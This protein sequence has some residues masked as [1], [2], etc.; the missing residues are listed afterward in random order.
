MLGRRFCGGGVDELSQVSICGSSARFA[1]QYHT[2]R[3]NGGNPFLDIHGAACETWCAVAVAGSHCTQHVHETLEPSPR[4][5]ARRLCL[6]LVV[7]SGQNMA[8][9]TMHEH[10]S[11]R[12]DSEAMKA[13]KK[14][15][16][17][18]HRVE[19]ERSSSVAGD[20][21]EG[22]E[23]E[24]GTYGEC[25]AVGE[26]G[27]VSGGCSSEE[28]RT[29]PLQCSWAGCVVGDNAIRCCFQ[30]ID[31]QAPGEHVVASHMRCKSRTAELRRF[32]NQAARAQ[33][34]QELNHWL[35]T[36]FAHDPAIMFQQSVQCGATTFLQGHRRCV[37]SCTGTCTCLVGILGSVRFFVSHAPCL[38]RYQVQSLDS[39]S[40]DGRTC[41]TRHVRAD[42]EWPGQG[43]G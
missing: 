8:S 18:P 40:F 29:Q 22:R 6:D 28:A 14:R 15:K 11:H 32:F 20:A 1:E 27:G 3:K 37:R 12:N 35:H 10:G 16:L 36:I 2:T 34:Q 9:A 4:Q 17:E 30:E 39:R 43:G 41:R 42:A 13:K 21:E 7:V 33:Q 19:L 5:F 38:W 23:P 26:F 24:N 31:G 25:E